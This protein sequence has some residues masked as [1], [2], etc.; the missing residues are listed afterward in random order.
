ME[1]QPTQNYP[2]NEKLQASTSITVKN[3]TDI[4]VSFENWTCGFGFLIDTVNCLPQ[5]TGKVKAEYVW[6]D[7]K[8]IDMNNKVLDTVKGVYYS[9]DVIL[10]KNNDGSFTLSKK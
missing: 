9:Q 10:T 6:Y 1:K 4:T 8:A 5:S 3:N 7:F 2:S